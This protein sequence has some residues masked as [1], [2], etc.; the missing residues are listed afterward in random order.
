M[1]NVI[2]T[3]IVT[4]MI[5]IISGLLLE[6]F[7][8]LAPKILCTIGNGVPMKKNGKR[9]YAYVVTVRNLSNKIV[10][11]LT[12]NI[13]S[14]KSNLNI[15]DTKITGGLKFDSSMEEDNSIDIEIPFLSNNDEFSAKIYVENQYGAYD[16]PTVVIRSPEKFKKVTSAEQN[17]IFASLFNIPKNINQEISNKMENTKAGVPD[18]KDDFTMVMDKPAGAKKTINKRNREALHRNKKANKS[19]QAA[20]VI[21][22]IIVF[23]IA[24][25]SVKSYF[26]R[27]STN[28]QS[29]AVENTV[30]KQ[31]TDTTEST[32][33]TTKN[34]GSKASIKG[35]S[36][37]TRS[38]T[39]PSRTTKNTDTKAPAGDTTGN[40]DTKSST[41]DTTGNTD[42][43][44]STGETTGNTDTKTSTGGSTGNTD[45]KTSTGGTTGNTD[46][47]TSAGEAAQNTGN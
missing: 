7:K 11:K 3:A 12:L 33:G 26:K 2:K 35:A 32:R 30:P 18:E 9:I 5:S 31:S 1:M 38:N 24:G 19:K 28:T 40:T 23:M 21:A 8:N 43:K 20:I 37:N 10:H 39:S 14:L 22:S 36:G 29:P 42:K 41:G 6:Y 16:K 27:N 44:E 45:S 25:V 34:T 4:I 17:G 13:Q 47:N 15:T 46:S